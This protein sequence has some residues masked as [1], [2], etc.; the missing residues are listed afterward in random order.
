MPWQYFGEMR[1]ASYLAIYG[2]TVLYNVYVAFNAQV[3][4]PTTIMYTYLC[5]KS[6]VQT[7][8]VFA[9]TATTAV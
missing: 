3:I 2:L 9:T 4:G 7:N 1:S 5:R 8:G 6:D